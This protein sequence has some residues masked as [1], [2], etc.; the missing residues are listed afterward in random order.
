MKFAIYKKQKYECEIKDNEVTLF[1]DIPLEGSVKQDNKFV[2]TVFLFDCEKVYY[3]EP[4]YIYKDICCRYKNL[5]DT[6]LLIFTNDYMKVR[7]LGFKSSIHEIGV[8]EKLVNPAEGK[9]VEIEYEYKK[10]KL[11]KIK[12]SQLL[13][14]LN[15]FSNKQTIEDNGLDNSTLL[16]N[17]FDQKKCL[18]YLKNDTYCD[19]VMGLITKADDLAFCNTLND[20]KE[21]L[22]LHFGE[23]ESDFPDS[24]FVMKFVSNNAKELSTYEDLT[25]T[26]VP[27]YIMPN[28]DMCTISDEAM[29]YQVSVND[30]EK[31][32][33]VRVQGSWFLIG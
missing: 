21:A 2:K 13:S 9:F 33:A 23:S 11:Q 27:R 6:R 32:F 5:D 31:P 25:V 26:K 10:P 4:R 12:E 30:E 7:D 22:N 1:S 29:I 17:F 24:I 15:K 19:A 16:F 14:F 3:V 18:E 20:Y 8:Y 28:D